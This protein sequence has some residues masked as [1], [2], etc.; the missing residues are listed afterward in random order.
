MNNEQ[1]LARITNLKDE[2]TSLEIELAEKSKLPI[3]AK[4]VLKDVK[5][6]L[7]K[8]EFEGT[9]KVKHEVE[10]LLY[11]DLDCVYNNRKATAKEVLDSLYDD[12]G[13][14][15]GSKTLTKLYKTDKALKDFVDNA[16]ATANE[17][18]KSINDIAKELKISRDKLVELAYGAY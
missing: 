11:L 16:V 7:S 1:L 12:D 18:N 3:I 2:L 4:K 8:L 15:D 10:S 9:I 6:N 5:K 13:M 14:L 17:A